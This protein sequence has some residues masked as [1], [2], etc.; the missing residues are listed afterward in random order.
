[1]AF[2]PGFTANQVIMKR[3]WKTTMNTAVLLRSG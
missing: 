2:G 1:M 3:V